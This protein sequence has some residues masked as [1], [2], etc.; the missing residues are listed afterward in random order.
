MRDPAFT[1][2]RRIM[3]HPTH[4]RP[5]FWPFLLILISCG[6][7][8]A[9]TP[10]P[11]SSPDPAAAWLSGFPQ[12][13]L[14]PAPVAHQVCPAPPSAPPGACVVERRDLAG[15][16]LADRWT[17]TSGRLW[18]HESVVSDRQTNRATYRYDDR[19]R[20][21][22]E[23]VCV[24]AAAGRAGRHPTWREP[25]VYYEHDITIVT[26]TDREYGPDSDVPVFGRITST[27]RFLGR[28]VSYE[29]RLCYRLDARFRRLARYQVYRMS[30]RPLALDT[31]VRTYGWEGERL[32][33]LRSETR[34]YDRQPAPRGGGRPIHAVRY[35]NDWQVEFTHD[36][37]G[38]V[39]SFTAMGHPTRLVYDELGRLIRYAGLTISWDDRDRVLSLGQGGGASDRTYLRDEAGRFSGARYRDG[40]G[41]RL[42]YGDACPPDFTHR[43]L[44]PNVDNY[45]HYEGKDTL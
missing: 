25:M 24:E 34:N 31:M 35:R 21:V 3:S 17:F 28:T 23:T 9:P 11:A 42:Y 5:G 44:E 15:D 43:A 36:G 30:D 16:A 45:L 32:A 20:L 40:G 7:A 10:R 14:T 13:C 19:G 1:G 39:T 4:V 18:R 33:R 12:R 37:A 26:H 41:Y 29:M 6:R 2:A 22:R 38:R 27:S 8:V